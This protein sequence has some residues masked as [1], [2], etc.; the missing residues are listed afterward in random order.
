MTIQQKKNLNRETWK[1]EGCQGINANPM[2]A[3][4]PTSNP[5]FRTK[6]TNTCSKLTI[7]QWN[8]DSII[9]K[10]QELREYLQEKEIDIFMVQETKL[11]TS[12]KTPKFKNFTIIRQDRVQRKGDENNRGGGL[13]VGVKDTIPYRISR[14]EFANENDEVSEWNSIEIPIKGGQKLRLNNIYI[15]PVRNSKNHTKSARE[16]KNVISTDKWMSTSYDCLF[17]DFNAKSEVWDNQVAEGNIQTDDR[18]ELI[19]EWLSSTNMICLNNGSRTRTDRNDGTDSAPDISFVHSSL[20]EKFTWRVE[21]QLGSDHKPMII[22]YED[23]LN[24]P[25]TKNIP[26]YKWRLR[27]ANWA[28]YQQETEKEVKYIEDGSPEEMETDLREMMFQ[29]AEKHLG[30]RKIT[31]KTKPWLTPEIKAEIKKCN[32]LRKTISSNRKEWTGA[33]RRVAELVK[34]EKQKRWKEYVEQLD[35]KTNPKQVWQTIRGMD[36]R[37]PD[38]AKNEALVIDG[39]ALIEDKDK[40]EAFAKTYRGFSRLKARKW[41]R[42][43]RRGV[44]KLLKKNDS[45][46]P[47]TCEQEITIEELNRVINEA[48]LNKAAGNDEICYELIKNLGPKAR[49]LSLKIF[50][51]IWTNGIEL[52]RNWRLAIIITLLKEGKYQKLTS[53]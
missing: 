10:V 33:C 50:N 11:I 5:E 26:K 12:D 42:T 35:M 53:S 32:E 6:S 14:S 47:E 7:L 51:K 52:P 18:G 45:Y 49:Q 2:P 25:V 19:E 24:I 13:L 21:D 9:S 48:G 15:P 27:D 3:P 40:A 36:G 1:C 23:E 41:D 39:V 46:Q 28:K 22:T 34:E 4:N 16:K 44:R 20:A 17:G 37:H 31:N 29:T 43:I 30:K 8:A 38:T